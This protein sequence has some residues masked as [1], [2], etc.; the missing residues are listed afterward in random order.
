MCPSGDYIWYHHN[1]IIIR[2]CRAVKAWLLTNTIKTVGKRRPSSVSSFFCDNLPWYVL[3]YHT[4]WYGTSAADLASRSKQSG[5]L[6]HIVPTNRDGVPLPPANA[7][8]LALRSAALLNCSISLPAGWLS[9]ARRAACL[10]M[11][12]PSRQGSRS[13][14]ST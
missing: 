4:I 10:S 14:A 5:G 3:E 7:R 2:M 12:L 9:T 11:R 1:N 8:C 13:M 6:S